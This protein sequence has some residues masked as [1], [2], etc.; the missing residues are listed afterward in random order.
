MIFQYEDSF[1]KKFSFSSNGGFLISR[2]AAIYWAFYVFDIIND[3]NETYHG[4]EI[5]LRGMHKEDITYTFGS[6]MSH[7][8]LW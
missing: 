4:L 8:P 3:T 6:P 1:G 5:E 2:R 7:E